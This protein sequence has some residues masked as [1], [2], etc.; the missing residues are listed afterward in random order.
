MPGPGMSFALGLGLGVGVRVH[1]ASRR[2][3]K[4]RTRRGR[5]SRDAAVDAVPSARV[6][7]ALRRASLMA[8]RRRPTP[9]NYRVTTP[10]AAFIANSGVDAP[11]RKKGAAVVSNGAS[12]ANPLES[13]CVA[14]KILGH[15]RAI[16]RSTPRSRSRS[17]VDPAPF[18]TLPPETLDPERFRHQS[19]RA[20][21]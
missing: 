13:A 21:A 5:S 1:V 19:V 4:K 2:R 14:M 15:P 17:R 11:W 18:P 20:A 8:M 6:D 7:D 9:R 3:E 16:G 12:R 10:T